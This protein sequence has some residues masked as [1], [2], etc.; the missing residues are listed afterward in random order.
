MCPKRLAS[1]AKPTSRLPG[2]AILGAKG[3]APE[4]PRH[5]RG[6]AGDSC[7][8]PFLARI[9]HAQRWRITCRPERSA[10][11]LRDY[12]ACYTPSI[13]LRFCSSSSRSS[14]HGIRPVIEVLT[15]SPCALSGGTRMAQNVGFTR[16]KVTLRSTLNL[17]SRL[18]ALY[19]PRAPADERKMHFQ[20]RARRQSRCPRPSTRGPTGPQRAQ[21]VNLVL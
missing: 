6:A 21:L 9:C 10:Y 20:C 2:A 15:P 4:E 19:V 3:R 7:S 11:C 18:A 5:R 13:L 17:E 1:L 14:P 12:E 8:A 16:R